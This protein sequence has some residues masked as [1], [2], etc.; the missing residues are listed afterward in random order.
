[1]RQRR[2]GFTLVEVMVSLGVMTV[3]AMSIIALQQQTTRANVHAREVTAATQI[4]Q[5]VLERLKLEAVAWN[6]VT[7]SPSTDLTNAPTLRLIT[8]G[9]PGAFMGLTPRV[10]TGGGITRKLSNAFDYYG[11]DVDLTNADAAT[12]AQ[13][14]FC[15]GIRL[16][17]IYANFRA[18][19]A[20]VRVFWPIEGNGR[21]IT[22]DFA[23][24]VDDNTSLN[25]NGANYDRYHIIYLSTVIRPA[26]I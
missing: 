25:P 19:R 24:C 10:L 18:M 6:N 7:T 13:V 12:L 14:H 3:G 21:T 9:T 11:N 2:E 16:S 5:N 22:T 20:D 8:G 17:W 4:A 26:P 1:M 15:A 23:G